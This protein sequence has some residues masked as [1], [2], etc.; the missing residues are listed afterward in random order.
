MKKRILTLNILG[1]CICL[2]ISTKANAQLPFKIPAN[3]PIADTVKK[4]TIAPRIAKTD[5]KP[6]A[7]I[8]KKGTL[9]KK[10]LFT[11]H[12]LKDQIFFEIPDSILGR[13]IMVINKLSKGPAG[14]GVYAGEELDNHT[15][16][17]RFELGPDSTIRMRDI[18][19]IAEAD[20]ADQINKAV[21]KSSVAPILMSFQIKALGL[22]KKSYVIE[23]NKL[24]KERSFI[25]FIDPASKLGKGVSA[26]TL[27]DIYLETFDAY[28]L[29]VELTTS[30]TMESK[31]PLMP[32]GTLATIE[33][34]TSFIALPKIP[35]Q[36]RFKDP[37][38]GYFADNYR[39]FSDQQQKSEYKEF[40][41]KWRLEPKPQDVERYKKGELV[42]PIKPIVIYI[43]PATPKQW[44][45]YLIQGINDWQKAFEQAGF[46]NAIIGREWPENDTSMNMDDA[47]YSL[48]RYLPS[49][50]ANAYGPNIHDPR[51][52]EIIQTN[53]GWYHNVMSVLHDWY[54]V[55]AG[56]VD[57]EARKA[58]FS[59]ELMGKLIRFV[60]SHEIGHT[61]GLRH[62]FLASSQTPVD[63]LRSSNYLKKYGHTSSIMDYA[64]FNYV[65]QPEDH[66]AQ[67]ELFPR[68][69]DYDIWAIEWGY[70]NLYTGNAE[71]DRKVLSK[72]IK[73]RVKP[74]SRLYWTEGE[75]RKTDPRSQTEDLG[76]NAMKASAYGIK[77]LKRILPN[78]LKWSSEENDLRDNLSNAYA[79]VLQQY[80]RYVNHVINYVGASYYDTQTDDSAKDTFSPVSKSRQKEALAFFANEVFNTPTW[81]LENAKK[82]YQHYPDAVENI[83][84]RTL[85]TLLDK[86]LLEKQRLNQMAYGIKAYPVEEYLGD[87]HKMIWK[88]LNA[89]G[90]VTIDGYHRTLQKTYLGNILDMLLA[91]E[92]EYTDTDIHS[93]I[94]ME[95][96]K[97]DREIGSALKK[98]MGKAERYH[99][100]DMRTRIKKAI[101]SKV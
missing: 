34:R 12:Q 72:M 33:V 93:V 101:D 5:I 28:P 85:N 31:L 99:L 76:D 7:T 79:T 98:Q 78:V 65:A 42:E 11:V 16:T 53:I 35:M 25:N 30:K 100:V 97:I 74:G 80:T 32:T 69:G 29:N 68:I 37:R 92:P 64:R 47:R 73:D 26:P 59:D 71:D 9:S 17:I 27:K 6:Y 41:L 86:D 60:S 38:V 87:V 46:K 21:I 3:L 8:I 67:S 50:I 13:D 22:E 23:A 19:L 89:T 81:L 70:K 54:M 58:K 1:L 82:M 91:K 77:N 43:D 14:Y 24:V 63:S 83:Q 57:P 96:V 15:R 52:G 49:E 44:R 90:K 4:D 48:V 84:I 10:G 94:N 39:V 56:A 75:M 36:R 55:Q 45:P 18:L 88:E 95:L 66:I 20:S 62:N 2:F 61:L 51:S 40:I